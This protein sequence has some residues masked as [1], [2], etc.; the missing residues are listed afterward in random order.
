MA[1]KKERADHVG[2]ERSLF[3]HN[4]AILRKTARVCA[5]CGLPLDPTLKW[6]DPMCTTIDH[7]IPVAL[8]GRSTLDNL[9][10]AHNICN[11]QKGKKLLIRPA[12]DE[13]QPDIFENKKKFNDIP[14]YL[15]WTSV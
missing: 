7:R 14:Q 1:K 15:D 8:G 2:T 13:K 12:S 11:K 3:L 6:P 4:K 10:A 9:Q 5:L